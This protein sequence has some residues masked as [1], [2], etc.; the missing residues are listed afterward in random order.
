ML[1]IFFATLGS[2]GIKATVTTV[3]HV[4]DLNTSCRFRVCW[5][6]LKHHTIRTMHSVAVTCLVVGVCKAK[7]HISLRLYFRAA[8]MYAV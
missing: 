6:S 7:Q 5:C 1:L 4:L 3:K 8:E 2:Q